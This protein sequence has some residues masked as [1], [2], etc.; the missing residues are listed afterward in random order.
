L[1]EKKSTEPDFNP[2]IKIEIDKP[3]IYIHD[4]GFGISPDISNFIF[5]PFVSTKPTKGRGLGLFIVQQLLDSM[6]CS[7][8]LDP[9][10]NQ[11]ERQYIFS[12]NLANIID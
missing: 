10:L 2:E 1:K 12:I 4:N 5:E 9:T 11:Y 8:I 3:W 7:I 6:N